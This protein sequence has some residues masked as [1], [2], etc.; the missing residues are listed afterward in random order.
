MIERYIIE[1]GSGLCRNIAIDGV[2]NM[3]CRGLDVYTA[4]D[5]VVNR[6]LGAF[7]L[8][9]DSVKKKKL[10]LQS[11]EIAVNPT[12]TNGAPVCTLKTCLHKSVYE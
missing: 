1:A 8:K 2:K 11:L 12:D 4:R 5:S 3:Q 9:Q 6:W 10:L 7:Q